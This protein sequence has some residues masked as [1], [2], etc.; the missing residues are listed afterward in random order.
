[1]I[2]V[3]STVTAFVLDK[4]S[5]QSLLLAIRTFIIMQSIELM[6]RLLTRKSVHGESSWDKI[7]THVASM[8]RP[9]R[10]P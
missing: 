7:N 6:Q 4:Q 3:K 2:M 10:R 8:S 5:L 1:M 9:A